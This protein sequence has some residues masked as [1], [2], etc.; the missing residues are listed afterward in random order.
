MN[1]ILLLTLPLLLTACTTYDVQRYMPYGVN[2]AP[3]PRPVYVNGHY[4]QPRQQG[5]QQPH[6]TYYAQPQ[7]NESHHN[8]EYNE[9]HDNGNIKVST[10]T[11]TTMMINGVLP[12]YPVSRL[13]AGQ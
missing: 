11:N 2:S 5:Y 4:Q 9:H 12:V 6:N 8:H 3:A 1:K 13:Y 10:K 7:Y